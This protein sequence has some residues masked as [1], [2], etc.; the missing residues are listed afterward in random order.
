MHCGSLTCWT[1][2]AVALR[3]APSADGT[4]A[5]ESAAAASCDAAPAASAAL[6]EWSETEDIPGTRHLAALSPDC[7]RAIRAARYSLWRRAAYRAKGAAPSVQASIIFS[8]RT[9]PGM[10]N[11]STRCQ[12]TMIISPTIDSVR[13]SCATAMPVR[14]R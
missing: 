2:S 12:K 1:I 4:G 11:A 6:V 7:A 5:G 13:R 8:R 3:G 14:L 10:R 9:L